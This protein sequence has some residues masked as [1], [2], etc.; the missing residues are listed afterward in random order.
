MVRGREDQEIRQSGGKMV[1]VDGLM[2]L[3]GKEIK[4]GNASGSVSDSTQY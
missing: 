4:D 1:S 2:M 3:A